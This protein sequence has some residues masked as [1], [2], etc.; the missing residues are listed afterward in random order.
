MATPHNLY[1][2][3]YDYLDNPLTVE[4]FA[5]LGLSE[6]TL[7]RLGDLLEARRLGTL[8]ARERAELEG[9]REAAFYLRMSARS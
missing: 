3:G 5:P 9:Y 1:R 4:E 8:S 7:Q 6:R 2:D